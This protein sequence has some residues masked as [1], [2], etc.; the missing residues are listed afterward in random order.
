[1]KDFIVWFGEVGKADLALVGG[2]GA[3]LGEMVRIGIPVPPGF[4]V[5][6]KAYDYFLHQTGLV[7][8]FE[9]ITLDLD[10]N[11]TDKLY[12]V[13]QKVQSK[14]LRAQL[15]QEVCQP[16][17]QA[18]RKLDRG[19]AFVAVRSSATAEDLPDASFAGQQ[20]TFLNV[21]GEQELLIS[22]K[23][24]WASL[25]SPRAIFYRAQKGFNQLSVKIAVPIQKMVQSDASG[26]MFTI[27]P[28]S[29]DKSTLIIEA[30]WGLG[31][32]IVQGAVTPDTYRVDKKNL[33]IIRKRIGSQK[34]QLIKVGKQ[35][36]EKSVAKMWQDVQKISDSFITKLSTI[37][38][39]LEKH[40]YFPQDIEWAIENNKLYI[41][42][43]RAV[44][45]LGKSQEKKVAQDNRMPI[46]EGSPA[47]PG[48]V[49]GTVTII[50][51]PRQLDKIKKGD[52]LV[53]EKT[54]PD[55]VPGMKRAVGIVTDHGGETSHAAIVSRELGI[56][57]VV[58]TG[59][60]TQILKD[61]QVITVDGSKGKIYQGG[62]MI[63][64]KS[65]SPSLAP[66]PALAKES[67]NLKTAT[68]IYV[69]LAEPDLAPE[70]AKRPVD[71][72]GLLRA[73]FMIAQLGIHPH[74]LLNENK[75]SLLVKTIRDGILQFCQAFYPRPVVYRATDF[76]TNE[77]RQLKG[78][79][80]YEPEEENPFIGYR[81]A[82]RYLAD[83]QIFEL[84]IKA[85]NQV[86]QQGFSNLHLM[87][88]FVR[89]VN[90]LKSVK[91]QLLS[92]GLSRRGNFELWMMVEIPANVIL[93]DQFL[94]V[95]LDGVSIGSNDLTMLI[96]G[97]DRD[98]ELLV[99]RF[100][101]LNPA[102]LWA[103]EKTVKTCKKAKVK[104]SICGQAP[105]KY[106]E[107]VDRLVEWGT[108]SISVNPDVIEKT[109]EMVSKAEEKYGQNKTR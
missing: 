49:A 35:T 62:L 88:P 103:L 36:K 80:T 56:P 93:L 2:K 94:K 63:G 40:Y 44:T 16:V 38:L 26:V 7:S 30:I 34:R 52:V 96:L 43:T 50:S 70:A 21:K 66:K 12:Q 69:N 75:G 86:R 8:S 27:D 23:K 108:T 65:I 51:G 83:P 81:G 15:P 13:A 78:G 10:V 84:E 89:T 5:T 32:L 28:I 29:E 55:Y 106:P 85:F 77:Y 105:S 24:C 73:E 90:E 72:V 60:A 102:V 59:K 64:E 101:E 92:Y 22:L 97:V 39:Q 1:M 20:A 71:G 18:Y 107:L 67:Y 46:L 100:D 57:C 48:R 37:G 79:A 6:A 47:S 11:D 53:A 3:N 68:K 91:R 14:I 9:E 99:E 45:T 98:N 4:I 31:E 41:L 42:Q 87:I 109:R 17:L 76:K 74:Q 95:G 82:F 54:T 25:F 104:V 58:G 33:K 61:D 19:K